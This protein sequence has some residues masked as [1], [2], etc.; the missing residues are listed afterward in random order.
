MSTHPT[1]R[2][3]ADMRVTAYLPDHGRRGRARFAR[4][5]VGE[6]DAAVA[7]GLQRT[8]SPEAEGHPLPAGDY[9]VLL[10][11]GAFSMCDAPFMLRN[12][13]PF[14][15][16]AEGDILLTGLGLGC[17]VRGL[18]ARPAVRS[19]TVVELHRDVIDLIGPHHASARVELIHAD[20]LV[21]A[22]PA[23]RRFDAAML[24]ITDDRDLVER[25]VEHHASHVH[26]LWPNPAELSDEPPGP[27]LAHLVAAA[28]G[29][30]L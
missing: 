29:A 27:D 4:W 10:V 20:A 17:L 13:V 24:D 12:Y 1:D 7:L 15:E 8:W 21:W 3:L 14:L 26:A 19:I 22:P 28:T 30:V 25:L 6:P 16:S 18:L 9:T 5:S 23:G 2:P 11:D